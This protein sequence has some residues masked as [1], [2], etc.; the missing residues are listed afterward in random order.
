MVANVAANVCSECLRR[1]SQRMFAANACGEC[2]RRMLTT[3]R[4]VDVDARSWFFGRKAGRKIGLHG[5]KSLS[6]KWATWL[7]SGS[8]L[9]PRATEAGE[10]AGG[11]TPQMF[12]VGAK[13]IVQGAVSKTK[14]RGEAPVA[15]ETTKG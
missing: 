5:L 3:D 2:L 1:T 9:L 4:S 11:R 15:T 7:P 10:D 6:A 13:E 12:S 8:A 14:P